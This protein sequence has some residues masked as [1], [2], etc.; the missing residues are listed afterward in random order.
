MVYD[1]HSDNFTLP[2]FRAKVCLAT[3]SR[4]LLMVSCSLVCCSLKGKKT[5]TPKG[6]YRLRNVS[7]DVSGR[8]A[9]F[10]Y[11]SAGG[12]SPFL[13]RSADWWLVGKRVCR[14][15]CRSLCCVFDVMVV[16]IETKIRR[17]LAKSIVHSQTHPSRMRMA[18][19]MFFKASR[20]RAP[21]RARGRER[22]RYTAV[23]P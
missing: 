7:A 15:C 10:P 13:P 23:Y 9:I 19:S 12:S 5:G 21:Q 17:Q 2:Q 3:P 11:S 1:D 6:L 16:L 8:L 18:D 14:R 22:E 20:A 4:C